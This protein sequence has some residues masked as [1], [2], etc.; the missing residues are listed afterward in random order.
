MASLFPSQLDNF[1]N[2]SASSKMNDPAV[3][4]HKQHANINDAVEQLQ[5]K[6]GVNSSTDLTSMD[7][8]VT[9]LQLR[10]LNFTGDITGSGV[11][12]IPLV[13]SG[14]GIDAGT[15]GGAGKILSVTVD[16]KGRVTEIADSVSTGLKLSVK[17]VTEDTALT[18]L[19]YYV[20]CDASTSNIVVSLPPAGA[21]IGRVYYIVKKDNTINT[22]TIVSSEAATILSLS[23][24]GEQTN[25]ICD[26]TSWDIL[27]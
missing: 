10:T 20:K 23:T 27:N 21:N 5:L 6:V 1:T 16:T 7:S 17:T 25:I 11:T 12:S 8:K 14:T 22:V 26:G 3:A 24:A 19:E 4:H 15:Y 2:P 18:E 13:L 9:Q